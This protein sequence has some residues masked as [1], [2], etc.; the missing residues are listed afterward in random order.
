M[1]KIVIYKYELI[2]LHKD[3]LINILHS[4]NIYRSTI[5]LINTLINVKS[6]QL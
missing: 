6:L 4:S 2:K 3:Y 1:G 5:T